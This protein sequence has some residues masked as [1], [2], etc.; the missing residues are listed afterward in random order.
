MKHFIL[1]FLLPVLVAGGY[2]G[3]LVV[4]RGDWDAATYFGS[5]PWGLFFVAM[6]E[7]FV[8]TAVALLA[9]VPVKLFKR[10]A[11][12]LNT[13]LT[14]FLIAFS[15]FA[16]SGFTVARYERESALSLK[17]NAIIDC[18][19]TAEFSQQATTVEIDAG[20]QYRGRAWRTSDVFS[21]GFSSLDCYLIAPAAMLGDMSHIDFLEAWAAQEGLEQEGIFAVDTPYP[22]SKMLSRKMVDG[23]EVAFE[24]RIFLFREAFVL[25]VTASDPLNFPSE[26]NSAFTASIKVVPGHE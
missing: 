12:V 4:Y 14:V 22:H 16:V 8:P 18:P 17:S 21:D 25:T 10:D 20:E 5:D 2:F 3:W 9:A 23:R 15:V 1:K 24:H 11:S 26:R 13:W 19:I 6:G 7:A